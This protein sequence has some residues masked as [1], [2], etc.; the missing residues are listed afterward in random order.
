MNY[1]KPEDLVDL[2]ISAAKHKVKTPLFNTFILAILA[3]AFISFG[4]AASCAASYGIK[5]LGIAKLVSGV[6][7]PV[8]LIIIVLTG[9]H[10]FTSSC[11][12]VTACWA[13]KSAWR[14]MLKN[15]GIVYI[16]NF[17][18]AALVALAIYYSGE[19]NYS[20]GAL[21]GYTIKVAVQKL[22]LSYP[23]AIISGILCNILVCLA[24]ILS[25]AA[26]DIVGKVVAIF[27]PIF[28]FIISG[29]EHCVANMFYLPAGI[30]ASK[31]SQ[32][33]AYAMDQYHLTA[34]QIS[35]LD[36]SNMLC[37]NIIPVTIGNIIGGAFILSGMLYVAYK[38]GA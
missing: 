23:T 3:G 37:L 2:L 9:S 28:V 10:L 36:L 34:E 38:R 15:I 25:F 21:G 32:Y 4:A 5:S 31:N 14:A 24:V 17:I 33:A 6:V 35:T 8:G 30:L 12:N 20:E 22:T 26:R 1:N 18:G 13:K 7:F 29:F 19:F 11:M 27:C 16:G